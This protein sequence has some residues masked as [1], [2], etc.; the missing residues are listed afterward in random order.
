LLRHERALLAVSIFLLAALSWM[1]L[2]NNAGMAAMRPS[3]SAL[4]SMWWV[5]MVAMMLPSA[6]PAILLYAQVR[7][8]RGDDT[9]IAQPGV[10]LA[11]YLAVWL[12]FSITAA[13]AQH[14][15]TGT[16][17][18]LQEH[19]AQGLVLIGAG[20]YQISPMKSACVSQCRSPG[21]FISRHW[22]PGWIGAMRL[23]VIHGAYCV[24]CCWVLMALLFVGGVMNLL[25]VAGLTVLVAGEKLLPNGRLLQ[26][27]SGAA[28]LLWGGTKILL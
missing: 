5:M 2:I 6:T 11:G 9:T 7:H 12:L 10:F 14:L 22:R 16:S 26:Q 27:V 4:I 8:S 28:L 15:L 21:Q 24:G 25:W 23:G 3:L 13:L 17:M 19:F 1:F 18:A 20:A